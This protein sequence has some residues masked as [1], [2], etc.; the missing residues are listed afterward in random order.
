MENLSH[1]HFSKRERLKNPSRSFGKR[2]HSPFSERERSPPATRVSPFEKS[3]STSP[4][5]ERERSP[6]MM[7]PSLKKAVPYLPL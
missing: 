1:S 7:T 6:P 3:L 2:G 4:F 5:S